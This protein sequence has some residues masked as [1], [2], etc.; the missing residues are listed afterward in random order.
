MEPNSYLAF[1]ANPTTT[2]PQH[3]TTRPFY[4]T[5]EPLYSV[6]PTTPPTYQP[7]TPIGTTSLNFVAPS[8]GPG[9]A[10]VYSDG[11]LVTIS[12]AAGSN[13]L[14]IGDG[15]NREIVTVTGI[16]Y[17]PGSATTNGYAS[18]TITGTGPNGGF[19]K[20]HYPGECVSNVVPGNPGP[21][22]GFD[23]NSPTYQP[24]VP[25]WSRVP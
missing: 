15:A 11:V 1:L 17:Y 10:Q 22:P 24:V 9:F 23:V 20:N 13:T 2:T 4:T 12:A 25:L 16:T 6:P 21:Q 18:V 7:T 3:A 14:V 5:V 8:G 19:A